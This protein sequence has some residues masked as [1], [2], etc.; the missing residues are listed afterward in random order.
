MGSGD[1]FVYPRIA[2]AIRKKIEDREYPLGSKIPSERELAA[3]FYVNRMTV[4]R[5]LSI[6]ES[7][8]LIQRKR[9]SGTFASSVPRKGDVCRLCG[10][11]QT[12]REQGR[13]AGSRILTWRMLSCAP[14][15]SR[16]EEQTEGRGVHEIVRLRLGDD[17]P[18]SVEYTY[19]PADILGDV[20]SCNPEASSL[21]EIMEQR[22]VQLHESRQEVTII[23]AG[24]KEAKW[25]EIPAGSSVF[26]FTFQT[27]DRQGR[28]VEYCRAYMRTDRVKLEIELKQL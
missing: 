24:K 28:V 17:L 20:H 2:G 6:L 27:Y 26:L 22:G 7:E 13:K 23:K 5:A 25:L 10:F 4:R 9:G 19:V 21:Y 11:T 15:Y 8:G 12:M 14:V 3:E 18:V 1:R 16:M